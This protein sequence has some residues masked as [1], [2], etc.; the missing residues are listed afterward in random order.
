MDL[1]FFMLTKLK[2]KSRWEFIRDIG[3]RKS[4]YMYECMWYT[5]TYAYVHYIVVTWARVPCFC[6]LV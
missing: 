6:F 1:S 3:T 2:R 4:T 5:V